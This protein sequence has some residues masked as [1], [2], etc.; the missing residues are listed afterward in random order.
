MYRNG[1]DCFIKTLRTEGVYGLYKGMAYPLGGQALINSIIFLVEGQCMSV[2]Q[3][4]GGKLKM[5]NS[6]ISGATA[7]AIQSIVCSPMELIKLHMQLQGM[8]E[9]GRDVSYRGP[10]RT[11]IDIWKAKGMRRG[12]M[13]GFWSTVYR[14]SISFGLYFSSFRFF[15]QLFAGKESS[16]DDL[17]VSWLSLAGGMTGCVVWIASY[18]FDIVKTKLQTDGIST[19]RLEYKGTWDCMKKLYRTSGIRVFYKGLSPCL[20]RGFLNSYALLPAA[21]Y[22]KRYWP[23]K[24]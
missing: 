10:L 17:G 13:K 23:S 4:E 22:V 11:T 19:N 1:L 15:C 24:Q 7:G 16:I 12:L 20:I 14:E 18:P 8:G 5:S 9:G 6:V 2:L 3:P 21:E